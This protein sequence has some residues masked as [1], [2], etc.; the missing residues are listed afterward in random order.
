MSRVTFL[1]SLFLILIFSTPFQ[2]MGQFQ[3]WRTHT[4]LRQIVDLAASDVA[5]WAATDGGV[6]RYVPASGEISRFTTTEGLSGLEMSAIEYDQSTNSVWVGYSDGVLDRID[7]ESGTINSFLDI[8]RASQFPDRDIRTLKVT[9]DTLIVA[10]GFGIVLFS[11]N[12]GEVIETY[13]R[14]GSDISVGSVTD[15]TISSVPDGIRRLW[16]TISSETANAVV[17][18]PLGESNLQDPLA[19]N[20]EIISTGSLSLNSIAEYNGNIYVGTQGG[21]FIRE[22]DDQYRLLD[23]NSG[24]VETLVTLPDQLLGIATQA[25]VSVNE[26]GERRVGAGG[27]LFIRSIVE[28]PDGNLWVGDNREGLAAFAPLAPSATVPT[29]VRESFF[30]DGPYDGRFTELD[31]DMDGNLWLAGI[32]GTDTGFY[33]F[34]GQAE[35]VTYSKRFNDAFVGRPTRFEFIHADAQS[36]I[37]SGSFGGGLVQV[38]ADND[39]TFYTQNN[40]TL[41]I[42]LL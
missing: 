18:A 24:N 36:N 26:T 39:V 37:W 23:V 35:W 25:L 17:S 3:D 29:T 38:D 42:F 5:I 1:Y 19:W 9:G 41:R 12:R 32:R 11:A 20:T 22:G 31:F 27:L 21:L 6:F 40:S 16:V 10:T 7:V 8:P 2:A 13:S 15:L 33:R 14:F 34:D 28:G 4:S 30:P